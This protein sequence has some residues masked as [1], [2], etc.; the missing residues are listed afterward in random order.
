MLE[1]V[2]VP[3]LE[4]LGDLDKR[5][6][7]YSSLGTKAPGI[8]DQVG[9]A[10]ERG[11][12]LRQKLD[13]QINS[14]NIFNTRLVARLSW[15]ETMNL[16]IFSVLLMRQV[17][18]A[19]IELQPSHPFNKIDSTA[20]HT[21][22]QT[23]VHPVGSDTI[24][25]FSEIPSQS[26]TSAIGWHSLWDGIRFL[27]FLVLTLLVIAFILV[28]GGFFVVGFVLF[29]F[30]EIPTGF[31]RCESHW[32]RLTGFFGRLFNNTFKFVDGLWD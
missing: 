7:K 8:C 3:L 14:L 10:W 29:P 21:L 18:G 6:R 26:E 31:A 2:S 17:G 1:S 25:N 32:K 20:V 23:L 19:T 5:L 28:V 30:V 12:G 16:P 27:V 15:R 22:E 11:V 24:Q 9:W 13:S 4:S